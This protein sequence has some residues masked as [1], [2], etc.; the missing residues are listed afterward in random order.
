MTASKLPPKKARC[1]PIRRYLLCCSPQDSA[2][3]SGVILS[4]TAQGL[5]YSLLNRSIGQIKRE[6][7]RLWRKRPAAIGVLALPSRFARP[8]TAARQAFKLAKRQKHG[9]VLFDR[10]VGCTEYQRKYAR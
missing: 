8:E 5:S 6:V 2:A 3:F 1:K 4:Y 9:L 10:A 7:Q